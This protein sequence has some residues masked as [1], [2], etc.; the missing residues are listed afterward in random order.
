MPVWR[1]SGGCVKDITFNN[2]LKVDKF[3]EKK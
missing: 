3:Y 1:G 2:C